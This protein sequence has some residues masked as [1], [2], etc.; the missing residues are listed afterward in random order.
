MTNVRPVYCPIARTTASMSAL[1]KFS[2]T[3]SF[4]LAS[5]AAARLGWRPGLSLNRRGAGNRPTLSAQASAISRDSDSLLALRVLRPL[6][7]SP[8]AEVQESPL[9]IA[10]AKQRDEARQLCF[11]TG[12]GA[13]QSLGAPR[14]A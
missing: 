1:T 8:T 9:A 7:I 5:A 12:V 2:M 3:L 14:K 10:P 4:A 11:Y 6:V 13:W